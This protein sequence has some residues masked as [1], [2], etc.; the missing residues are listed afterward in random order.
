[1]GIGF[2]DY[3]MDKGMDSIMENSIVEDYIRFSSG[4]QFFKVFLLYGK[5]SSFTYRI[6]INALRKSRRNKLVLSKQA[7]VEY[8]EVI[9][10]G[11]I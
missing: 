9:I 5:L 7:Y 2:S 11:I 1:M 10:Y 8:A 3:E 4:I 6:V